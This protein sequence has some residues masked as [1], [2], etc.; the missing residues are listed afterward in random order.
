MRIAWSPV[1]EADRHRL[2]MFLA[3][4]SVDRAERVESRLDRRVASLSGVPRQGRR[5]GEG[6]RE[7]SIPDIQV[8]VVYRIVEEKNAIHILRVW[9]TRQNREEP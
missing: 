8:S 3:E 7:L 4:R 2:W 5:V 9:S 1:A 6:R